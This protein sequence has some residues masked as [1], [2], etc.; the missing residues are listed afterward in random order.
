MKRD[1]KGRFAPKYRTGSPHAYVGRCLRGP[2]GVYII[3]QVEC[4]RFKLI[5]MT[6]G[7][8]FSDTESFDSTVDLVEYYTK[9]RRFEQVNVSLNVRKLEGWGYGV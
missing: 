7:N 9:K 3:A 2:S 8:R 1:S 5:G 4:R 6:S